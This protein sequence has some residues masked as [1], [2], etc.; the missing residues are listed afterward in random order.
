MK[1][2]LGERKF[3]GL[4][5]GDTFDFIS[6][7]PMYNSFTLRCTKISKRKYRDESGQDHSVGSHYCAVYHV[8]KHEEKRE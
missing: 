7:D 8:T 6:P 4:A 1:I 5:I 2:G 3:V